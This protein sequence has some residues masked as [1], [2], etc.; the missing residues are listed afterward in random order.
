MHVYH[1]TDLEDASKFGIFILRSLSASTFQVECS[2]QFLKIY[3]NKHKLFLFPTRN[4]RF[5]TELITCPPSIH[6]S[7]KGTKQLRLN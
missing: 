4:L 1:L 7:E 2:L 6:P 5:M 3:I